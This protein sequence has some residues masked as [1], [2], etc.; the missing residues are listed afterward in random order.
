MRSAAL[1]KKKEIHSEPRQ[2]KKHTENDHDGER[3]SGMAKV[4]LTILGAKWF[5]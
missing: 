4:L 5:T 1:K 3:A 2:Y